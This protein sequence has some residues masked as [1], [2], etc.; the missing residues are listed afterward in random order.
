MRI[1]FIT[2]ANFEEFKMNLRCVFGNSLL[3]CLILFVLERSSSDQL[4]YWQI[5]K[6]K[7]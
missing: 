3:T 6:R 4:N 1:M 5:T 2:T 7:P